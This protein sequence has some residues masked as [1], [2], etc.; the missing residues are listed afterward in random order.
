MRK[1]NYEDAPEWQPPSYATAIDDSQDDG[2]GGWK[3]PEYA[4]PVKPEE[5]DKP[6]ALKKAWDRASSPLTEAPTRAAESVASRIRGNESSKTRNI[7]AAYI[8][9]LGHA[10]SGLTS[11]L[12]LTFAGAGE[13]AALA[14][15][16]LPRVASALRTGTRALSV[17]V[18]AEGVKHGYEGVKNRDFSEF[19]SGAL[20]AG[21]GALGMKAHAPT[22]VE[23]PSIRQSKEIPYKSNEPLNIETPA[24][25]TF[26]RQ[27]VADFIKQNPDAKMNEISKFIQSV[28]PEEPSAV[29]QPFVNPF[30]SEKALP[31]RSPNLAAEHLTPEETV[32][33]SAPAKSQ[34]DI[35]YELARKRFNMGKEMPAT[36]VPKPQAEF[37]ALNEQGQPMYNIV[38]DGK[39]YTHTGP[40]ELNKRGIEVPET[41]EDAI[42]MRGEDI[43]NKMLADQKGEAWTPPEYAKPAEVKA[44]EPSFE[45]LLANYGGSGHPESPEYV[46]RVLGKAG[47]GEPGLSVEDKDL[48]KHVVYRNKAGEP[49][50][51]AKIVTDLEG[52]NLVQD[53]AVNKSKGLLTGRAMKAIGDKLNELGATESSGTMS[54][55]A[56]N[57][58]DRMKA[59][60]GKEESRRYPAEE[61]IDLGK[62]EEWKPPE[63]AKP[64]EEPQFAK[65]TSGGV[66]IGADVESLGKV[67]GSSLYA[68]NIT[69]IATKELLQNSVDA[70]RHLDTSGEI[71]VTLNRPKK[72]VEVK[73]NGKGLTKA[74]L[75]SVFTDLGSSGKRNDVDAAGG[76]GLAKAAPL[77]GGERVEVTSV[78]RENGK[79][80]EHKFSGT[81]AEL[82]K[83]VDIKT[84]IYETDR[85]E[86]KTGTTVRT[87]VPKEEGFYDA[88]EFAKNLAK[89]SPGIK[90]KINLKHERY[91]GNEANFETHKSD[92]DLN[93]A[94]ITKLS[95]DF[96]N[97]E[98]IVPEG[99]KYGSSQ[100]VGYEIL[101]NGLWQ[102]KGRS[103]YEELHGIPGRLLVNI[104]SKVPE[105]HPDY[106]FT[107]NRETIRGSTQQIIDKYID[108][109]IIKP[110]IGK[111]VDELKKLYNSMQEINVGKGEFP[112]TFGHKIAIYDP[113]GQITPAEMKQITSDTAFQTLAGNIAGTLKEAITVVGNKIWTDRLEKIG[114]IFDDKLHGIHIPNPGSGKSAILIN[115]FIAI[116]RMSPDEASAN[117]LHTILHEMAHIEPER[118]GHN[119]SFTKRLGDI[120]GKFG[121]RRSVEAQDNILNSIADKN[122]G[123]YN[124]EIQKVLQAYKE[125]RGREGTTEDLLSGTGIK[126]RA[127]GKGQGGVPPG[128]KPDGKRTTES[129]VKKLFSALEEAKASNEEQQAINKVERARRFAAFAGVKEEGSIGAAKSLSTLRGEFEKSEPGEALGLKKA[130]ADALFTAIK[131][132]QITEGEKARGYTALFK[133]MNGEKTPVRSEL[134]VLDNVF[135]N[136]FGSKITELHG[137]IGA[138]GLKVSKLANT[139]KSLQNMLSLAAPLRHGAGMIARKEFYPA[140]RDMFKFFGNKEFYEASMDAIHSDPQYLE[141]REAGLFIRKPGSVLESDE[142]F[143]NSYI[144]NIPRA[145]GIPMASAA[146]Q[147]AYNGFLNKLDFDVYKSM[148]KQAKALGYEATETIEIG[149]NK[150]G[151]AKTATVPTKEAKAIARYINTS[152]G[153][154]DLGM[155]NK[156]TNELNLVL[157]SPRMM[158]SR[159]QMFTNPKIYT[160]LPKGMR[161]DGLKS[162]L[163]IAALGTTIDTLGSLAGAKIS[164]NI[165]SS[166]FMKSRFGNKVI[167]PWAGFQQYVVAT[168]RFLAGKTDSKVPTSRLEIAGRFLASKEA[169]MI[170]FAHTILTSKFTGKSDNPATAGNMTTQYG[171]KTNIQS[172]IGK[173]FVPIFIQDLNDLVN[174]EPDFAHSVGLDTAMAGA[175]LAGMSQDY[176]EKKPMGFRKMRMR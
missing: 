110:S 176:P 125:S 129:A 11:P 127:G 7:L 113:K 122:T 57:F 58:M 101:N 16:V 96:A 59:R 52:K 64:S 173:Q 107:A 82:L 37:L 150:D 172:Q 112:N 17:P 128:D 39:R 75:Q 66:K 49:I 14:E 153:R 166:D 69:G 123:L 54:K 1:V 124:G 114:I 42:P 159:I 169:P 79:L 116:E 3:P 132:A 90:G 55:D 10:T 138:V 165:L 143:L 170:N 158:A 56:Q 117:I 133:L 20:E 140:F 45:D 53:L 63:Y 4:S 13:G 48:Y 131:R 160:S 33:Q 6:S 47:S 144:G 5:I 70:I 19:I 62:A 121:A 24:K 61:A 148:T 111:R 36:E 155:L 31:T 119:E 43:R 30:E 83:G 92:I 65:T 97:V 171:E 157:W 25:V 23:E 21:M 76:F 100:G 35:I 32:R 8:E 161:L 147:R 12:N 77:L 73:D 105:G 139:M 71:N 15:S 93:K 162:L 103:G 156:M 72:Y 46:G 85:P 2:E 164:T 9:G 94:D 115:P 167:D 134:N 81:P 95:G 104:K 41:P 29:K 137:G 154:G 40:E 142:E 28:K 108:E 120:Y 74:E 67:L 87:Y 68:G 26:T 27:K 130:E 22:A 118:A 60:T 141:S 91:E 175:S 84:K 149:K 38:E 135:G 98:L 152:T 86:Y 106:P 146:S 168:A 51:V 50:A 99:T 102:G 89:N 126:S 145:S 34:D 136:G 44:A 78:V 163:G 80:L 174:A 151:S 109:N 18:A 88:D